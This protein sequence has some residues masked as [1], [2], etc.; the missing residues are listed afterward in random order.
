M[1]SLYKFL[2]EKDVTMLEINPMVETVD[3]QGIDHAV[4]YMCMHDT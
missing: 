4:L 3:S 2:I 1:M